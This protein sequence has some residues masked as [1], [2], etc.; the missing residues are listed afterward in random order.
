MHINYKRDNQLEY[1]QNIRKGLVAYNETF[2]S[3][4]LSETINIYV[5][6][7]DR[8]VGGCHT[9][10]GWNWVYIEEL[11]YANQEILITMMNELY[12]IFRE[13]SEGI[14][15]EFYMNERIKD[16]KVAG[17][18][19]LGILED[20]PIGYESHTLINKKMTDV[21]INHH[22]KLEIANEKHEVYTKIIEEQVKAYNKK[23]KIDDAK[24]EMEFV[25]C[26][27]E[28]VV[29]GV[30]GYLIQDYLYVS[31][32][33]VDEAYRGNDIATKLMNLIEDEAKEKGY[34]HAY[35]GTCTF[36]AK[37]FYEKRGYKVKMIVSNCPKGYDDYTMVKK[38]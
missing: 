28:I 37:G 23:H 6:D 10:L 34:K 38:I 7:S 21:P 3:D 5:F 32:L 2:V 8:L 11:C 26:D 17:F 14:I 29:G 20:K 16:F 4:E 36:Q 35:L 19:V 25:A 30:Y 13:K 12:R 33:W 1:K 24:I 18:E 9:E 27:Q 22:Y 31:R 15:V